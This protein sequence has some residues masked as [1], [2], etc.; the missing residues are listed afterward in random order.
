[1]KS[2]YKSGKSVGK[3]QTVPISAEDP[4]VAWNKIG[5]TK[6]LL[7]EKALEQLEQ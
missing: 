3:N 1:M 2:Q 7:S 5:Q 6:T 4:R